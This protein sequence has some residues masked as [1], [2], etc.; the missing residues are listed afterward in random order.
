MGDY[1]IQKA[2]EDHKLAVHLKEGMIWNVFP[3]WAAE[4]YPPITS[5]FQS[6]CNQEG[7]VQE[8]EGW[9]QMLLKIV[10]A[11]SELTKSSPRVKQDQVAK[12]VLRSQPPRGEDVPDM[13]AYCM[14]WSG[15]AKGTFIK[16]IVDF[17]KVQGI[18]PTRHVSAKYFKVLAGLDFG[19]NLPAFA[20]TAVL[21]RIAASPKVMDGCA[22]YVPCTAI[23]SMGSTSKSKSFLEANAVMKR[24]KAIVDQSNLNQAKK[25]K[26]QS[27][28]E[29]SIIDFLFKVDQLDGES[30][31]T[32][33]DIVKAHTERAFFEPKPADNKDAA[34]PQT[35]EQPPSNIAQYDEQGNPIAIG[36]IHVLNQGF[37]VGCNVMLSKS[38]STDESMWVIKEIAESGETTL[39]LLDAVGQRQSWMPKETFRR[40]T[41]HCALFR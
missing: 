20:I 21:K 25:I 31:N 4:T 5:L 9:T 15:G 30:Y 34:F 19:V 13:V 29:M 40:E 23:N 39:Q 17:V 37:E 33:E 14:K 32:M 2:S 16:N 12:S 22:Q 3:H 18:P 27:G 24:F 35:T 10:A 26:I 38:K 41:L 36:K 11:S 1:P 6:A 7:Q 28:L 8:G